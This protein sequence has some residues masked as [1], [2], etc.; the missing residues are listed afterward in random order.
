MIDLEEHGF[1]G[2][3][4]G[5]TDNLMLQQQRMSASTDN[6]LQH[7]QRMSGSSDNLL[8]HQQ[9]MSESTDNL[10]MQQQ[11]QQRYAR[12]LGVSSSVGAAHGT[13]KRVGQRSGPEM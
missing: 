12:L 11:Q 9:R 2:H 6:L 1:A 13:S 3:M 10:L 5:S 4:A 8:Q 7:Q